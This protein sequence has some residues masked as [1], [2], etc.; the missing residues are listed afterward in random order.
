MH[1]IRRQSPL[2]QSVVC[3]IYTLEYISKEYEDPGKNQWSL[4]FCPV[5][6][7]VGYSVQKAFSL[8]K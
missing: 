2:M 1:A 6:I 4:L 5:G 7:V 8:I 3:I